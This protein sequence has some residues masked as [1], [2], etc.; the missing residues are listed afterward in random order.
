[1]FLLLMVSML[2]EGFLELS[3]ALSTFTITFAIGTAGVFII[4]ELDC[5]FVSLQV[6]IALSQDNVM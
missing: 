1:M 2:S 6:V 3:W 5:I 4:L